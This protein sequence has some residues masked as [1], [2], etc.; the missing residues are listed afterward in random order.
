MH[1]KAFVSCYFSW[2]KWQNPSS[3]WKC[4]LDINIY[5]YIICN[6]SLW[7]FFFY[8]F[9]NQLNNA[10]CEFVQNTLRY[11]STRQNHFYFTALLVEIPTNTYTHILTYKRQWKIRTIFSFS[12]FYSFNFLLPQ[13]VFFYIVSIVDADIIYNT[14]YHF[15][16]LIKN[17]IL[18]FGCKQ[19][20][21]LR[22]CTIFILL[23]MQIWLWIAFYSKEKNCQKKSHQS[24][25]HY[26]NVMLE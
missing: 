24:R 3:I 13:I 6:W 17:W 26:W 22:F 11:Q 12:P 20:E 14:S 23:N 8:F 25:E 4:T 1:L 21:H 5:L 7:L 9:Q 15:Q 10:L 19:W 16:I 2:N 18:H